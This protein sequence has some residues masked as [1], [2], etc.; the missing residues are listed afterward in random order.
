[1][2]INR[3]VT[4]NT[5]QIHVLMHNILEIETLKCSYIHMFNSR[6]YYLH[7]KKNGKDI[8]VGY[9]YILNRIMYKMQGIN[10]IVISKCTVQN[11]HGTKLLWVDHLVS[12]HGKTFV[13]SSKT[14][15]CSLVGL[16]EIRRKKFLI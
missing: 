13:V 6:E 7:E 15:L 4:L 11:F 10:S 16:H 5:T 9:Y 14:Y 8:T 1:M 12:T 2:Y 3:T